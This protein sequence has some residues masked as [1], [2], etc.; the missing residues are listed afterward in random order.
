MTT[1]RSAMMLAGGVVLGIVW[2]AVGAAWVAPNV[3]TAASSE[4]GG[5]GTIQNLGQAVIGRTSTRTATLHAG[6]VPC[7]V[8]ACTP[9]IAGFTAC[10]SGPATSS[11]AAACAC[12][13][14]DHDGDTDLADFAAHQAAAEP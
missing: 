2:A 7:Y 5:P 13:D 14:A 4:A 11:P 1:R 6:A 12:H 9:G 8:S 3:T 10:L